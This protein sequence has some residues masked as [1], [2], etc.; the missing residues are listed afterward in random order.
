[1]IGIALGMAVMITS[2]A[3]VVGFQ[4]EIRKKVIG[5]GAHIQIT[6][7]GTGG[8]IGSPKLEIDQPFYPHLD[9]LDEVESIHLYALKEAVIETD[10]NI[11]GII[12][13]GVSSD[14]NWRFFEENLVEGELPRLSP[15]TV[16]DAILLSEFLAKRLKIGLNDR[17][18]VYFQNAKGGMSQR[19]FRLKGTYN[20]GLQELDEQFALVDIGLIRKIN[21]WGL[22]ANIQ[23]MGCEEGKTLLKGF[24]FG[25]GDSRV[26]LRWSR[27][28]LVGEG[29]HAFC[30]DVGDSV[31][32]VAKA[33][34]TIP[35]TAFF[36]FTS[37]TTPNENPCKCP[38]EDD[39]EIG[40]SGGSGRYYTGGFEVMLGRYE[41]L[42]EMEPIIYEHLNYNLQTTTIRQK[43]PEI[44][45]WLEMLDLNSVIII[46]LMILISVI[47]MTSALLI[48]IME[49]TTMI[50]ILRAMGMSAGRVQNIFLFQAAYI[51]VLGMT[52]GNLI[53]LGFCFL[54]LK[55]GV[56]K[57]DPENYYVSEVP[58]LLKPDHVILLNAGVFLVCVLMMILPTLAVNSV[59]PS[60]AIRFN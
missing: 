32:V 17:V 11:Q 52:A 48:L 56:F 12:L 58:I 25:G 7:F 60:K 35:D 46:A 27:D 36:T 14:Y 47:N 5:F 30:L 21:Q 39:Y 6:N 3:I 54:Q 28:S 8:G 33:G 44:F 1:M 42:N 34:K 15:G 57:L 2:I 29:P 37:T 40:S 45:N 20:T 4:G 24:G 50:G 10:E 13:K 16:S 41:D 49:R 51:I 31:Y 26:K 55:T 59:R 22:E 19:N 38:G 18:T 43:T 23:W 9:T 53:G